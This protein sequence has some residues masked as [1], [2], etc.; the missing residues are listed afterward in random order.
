MQ[1]VEVGPAAT[2]SIKKKKASRR[3]K[4]RSPSLWTPPESPGV[5]SGTVPSS[6]KRKSQADDEA[7]SDKRRKQGDDVRE[8]A[9]SETTAEATRDAYEDS[10]YASGVFYRRQ[11]TPRGTEASGSG[12]AASHQRHSATGSSWGQGFRAFRSPA[13]RASQQ[14]T[15]TG[16]YGRGWS[17][18]GSVNMG[19]S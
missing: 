8:V 7:P 18:S 12:R 17:W 19:T 9:I 15:N 3:K 4:Q 16:T 2:G 13:A 14:G 10:T 1:S 5:A 6:R 11:Y